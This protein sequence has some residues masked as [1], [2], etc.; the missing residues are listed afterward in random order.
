MAEVE[1]GW[2]SIRLMT[3]VWEQDIPLRPKMLLLALADW[4][5]DEG[6]GIYP[7]LATAGRKSQMSDRTVRRWIAR[8]L[9]MGVLTA[10]TERTGGRG[11]TT[12]Y[13]LNLDVVERR[14]PW[15]GLQRRTNG[16]QRRTNG[17]EKADNECPGIRQDPLVDPSGTQRPRSR[18]PRHEMTLAPEDWTEISDED[19]AFIGGKLHLSDPRA[20]YDVFDSF[21]AWHRAHGT[22]MV[23]WRRGLQAWVLKERRIMR[24]R[25]L[26]ATH[27][28]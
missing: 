6:G 7:S 12:H 17:S 16:T 26:H 19:A 4:A 3:A 14:S 24:D 11:I 25:R 21:L 23:D 2:M 5:D 8:F 10:E 28:G 27:R 1:E 13:R 9:D 22:R 18:P 20:I 15:P